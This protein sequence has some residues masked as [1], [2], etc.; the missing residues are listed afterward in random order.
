MIEYDIYPLGFYIYRVGEELYSIYIGLVKNLLE[1]ILGGA[2]SC[3]A[4]KGLGEDN[5]II[6]T[7]KISIGTKGKACLGDF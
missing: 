6:Y 4:C 7:D 5:T 1:F 2:V 3:R